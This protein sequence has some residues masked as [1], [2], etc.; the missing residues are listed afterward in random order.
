ME[1]SAEIIPS[2]SSRTLNKEN[3]R[4]PSNV[5]TQIEIEHWVNTP[6]SYEWIAYPANK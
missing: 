6:G 3:L 1:G 4:Q 2:H 5:P